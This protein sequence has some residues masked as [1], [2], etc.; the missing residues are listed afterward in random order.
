MIRWNR[1]A[2][3]IAGS[4]PRSRTA[5]ASARLWMGLLI[6]MSLTACRGPKLISADEALTR[7]EAGRTFRAPVDGWFL[8]DALYR[9]YRRA[10]ADRI[11]E[12]QK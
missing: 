7:I 4:M 3:D 10:V 11:L 9:R 8:S 5:T 2:G 6:L 1:T 12:E